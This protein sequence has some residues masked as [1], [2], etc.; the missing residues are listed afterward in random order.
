MLRVNPQH[1]PCLHKRTLDTASD[2]INLLVQ[3]LVEKTKKKGKTKKKNSTFREATVLI[4]NDRQ[5]TT[6]KD[7]QKRRS[8]REKER[9]YLSLPLYLL[10]IVTLQKRHRHVHKPWTERNLTP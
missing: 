8:E 10:M 3:G 6:L 1:Y 4:P 5:S 2:Q 7:F 9:E